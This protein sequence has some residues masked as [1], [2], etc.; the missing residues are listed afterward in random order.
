MSPSLAHASSGV[1][2]SPELEQHKSLARLILSNAGIDYGPN[3]INRLVV[4]FAGRVERNGWAF[5]DYIANVVQLD[6]QTKARL[7][8][9]PDIA[10]AISYADPT[11]EQ[12]VHN[13][14][15]SRR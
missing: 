12:A 14:M 15:R 5:L 6:A 10:R 4:R 13:V 2:A 8:A 3:R 7:L 11:G 1:T 9:D